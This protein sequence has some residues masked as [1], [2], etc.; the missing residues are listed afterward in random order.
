VEFVF[1]DDVSQI[2]ALDRFSISIEDVRNP[3]STQ[4]TDSFEVRI[5]DQNYAVINERDR[6]IVLT[7]TTAWTVQGGNVQLSTDN[8][9][10]GFPTEITIEFSPEHE[11]SVG[12]GILIVY[13]PQVTPDGVDNLENI[14]SELE[15]TVDG[16]SIVM[17]D[18]IY[19]HNRSARAFRI[20]NI[21]QGESFVNDAEFSKKIVVKLLSLRNPFT[22]EMTDSFQVY[23][24]NI[25]SVGTNLADDKFFYIDKAT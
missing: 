10:P 2:R 13:P 23:S 6:G 19:D 16:Q 22:N 8:Q 24:F 11:I 3:I 7:T 12:G 25:K 17:Q 14:S 9:W 21:I 1:A 15:V 5:V 4:T 20:R 18:V